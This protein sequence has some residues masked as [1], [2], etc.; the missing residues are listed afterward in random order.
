[1]TYRILVALDGSPASEAVLKE[2]EQ[3]AVGGTSVH[4]LHVVPFLP[5]S[6]SARS[7]GVMACYDQALSYLGAVRERLPD[8]RGL[9]LIRA[10]DPADAIL[11]SALEFD[12]NL[13]AM[14]T[15][16]RAGLTRWLLGSAAETV[17]R[18]AQLPVLLRGA[19]SVPNPRSLRRILVPLD[20]SEDSLTILPTVK[21]LALRIGAEVV[22]LHVSENALVPP[23]PPGTREG[24][25]KSE[26]P[27]EKILRLADRFE[28]SDLVFW[29]TI[30]EGDPVEEILQHAKTLDADL[31]AMTTQA[32]KESQRTTIGSVAMAVLGRTDRAV[33]LQKPVVHQ[34]VPPAWK[35][36]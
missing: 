6:V 13:I 30:A 32:V 36:R 15:H 17:I 1:M 29:Q 2:V 35:F 20:G 27:K 23:P 25:G 4:L 31:I 11:Q 7:A 21:N 14:G 26:D 5:L 12:I 16:A 28:K 19:D 3:I 9:D 34:A 24:A 8:M 10:G 18:K 33:L 22:F